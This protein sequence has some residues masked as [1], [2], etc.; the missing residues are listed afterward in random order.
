MKKQA[1][2][3]S[4]KLTSL[5]L[6]LLLF[7][8]IGCGIKNQNTTKVYHIGILSGLSFFAETTD[9]FKTKMTELGYQEG[10]NVIYDIQKTQLN[11]E[12]ERNI[13]KKF[14]SDKVDLMFVFPTEPA[15]EAK[16][17]SKDTNIPVIFANTD[18]EDID[19]IKNVREPGENITGVRYQGSEIAVKR[20]EML[21]EIAPKAKQILVPYQKNYPIVAKELEILHQAAKI[22]N[23]TL[24]EFPADN[25]IG[26]AANLEKMDKNTPVD[27]VLMI[28]EPLAVTLDNFVLLAKFADER[29]IPF[30]GALLS[31]GNYTS[32]FGLT[33]ENIAIGKQGAILADKIFK[34]VPAG[35]IPVVSPENKLVINYKKAKE[36][37]F[38]I[39]ES[40]LSQAQEILR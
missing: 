37:G 20:L 30:G 21:H 18:I 27:A 2:S 32:M 24:I 5:L 35:S 22:M 9:G 28:A 6:F 26:L 29:K 23:V 15:I 34:G 13:L 10:K 33:P 31:S 19:L 12:E 4:I 11:L 17:I 38:T 3:K 25:T 1:Q 7:V 16:I 39:D 36:L 8:L 40:L 14:V